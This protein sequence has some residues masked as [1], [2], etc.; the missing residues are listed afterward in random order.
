LTK[1]NKSSLF[2]IIP[3]VEGGDITKTY[4]KIKKLNKQTS[5]KNHLTTYIL[6][7]GKIANTPGQGKTSALFPN[8]KLCFDV[9]QEK[10]AWTLKIILQPWTGKNSLQPI[11]SALTS[12][13]KNL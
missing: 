5:T 4:S 1:E 11:N 7:Q 2:H 8:K 9:R 3:H 6:G 13:R 10:S 12:N